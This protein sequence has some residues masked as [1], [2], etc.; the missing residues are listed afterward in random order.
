MG[1]LIIFAA[2]SVPYLV[3]SDRDTESLTVFGIALGSAA[4]GFAD[5]YIK[6]VSAVRSGSRRAGSCRFRSPSR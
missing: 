5:D 6:I 1:G 3:L 4:I 2:I